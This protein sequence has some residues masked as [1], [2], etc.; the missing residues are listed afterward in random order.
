MK[1]SIFQDSGNKYYKKNPNPSLLS[2]GAHTHKASL[3]CTISWQCGLFF[4][5]VKKESFFFVIKKN[6][7]KQNFGSG[8]Q[9][10]HIPLY[11]L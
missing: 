2:C 6:A 11:I 4:H 7:Q 8:P 9:F 5:V 1:F 10:I 3:F